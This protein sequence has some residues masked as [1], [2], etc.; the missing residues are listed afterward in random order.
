MKKFLIF[1]MMVFTVITFAQ[2]K[3][4]GTIFKQHPAI[5]VVESM[6]QAYVAG[7]ADKVATYLAED[8]KAFNGSSTNKND[9]GTNKEDFLSSVQFW[10]D[11]VDYLSITRGEGAY[12]D[13]LEYKESGTWVQTWDNLKGVENRTGVKLDM[14]IHRLF[15]V[16]KDNKIA[17]MI[18]Y[19]NENVFA[20]VRR[21]FAPRTNGVLYNNHENINK[22]RLM[23]AAFENGDSEKAYGFFTPNATFQD[24][25]SLVGE[26]TTMAENKENRNAFLEKFKIESVDVV[27]YPDYLEYELGGAKV[28]QS[29][30]NIRL[31]RKSDNK[32]I[33]LPAMY[34]HDFN[35]EGMITNSNSYFSSKLLE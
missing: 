26:T 14:P 30:W 11:N 13:A 34:I 18:T 31:T 24:L 8:F 23:F 28:V 16:N 25:N 17:T 1:M 6:Q 29:W 35:D 5:G 4:N 21:S 20:E 7:D 10:K 2:K 33:V 12:P 15:V 22:V 9:Q 19:S 3:E 27:G 32:N